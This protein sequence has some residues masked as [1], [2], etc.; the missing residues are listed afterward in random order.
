MKTTKH[1]NPLQFERIYL[2][3][4]QILGNSDETANLTSHICH[5]E[6]DL[7]LYKVLSNLL[8]ND[9]HIHTILTAI[10][11][12]EKKRLQYAFDSTKSLPIEAQ[13]SSAK[14]IINDFNDIQDTLLSTAEAHFD[15]I[16]QRKEL[17]IS[18]LETD[19]GNWGMRNSTNEIKTY[20]ETITNSIKNWNK[21]KVISIRNYCQGLTIRASATFIGDEDG[22]IQIK[23]NEEVARIFAIHASENDAFAV[24]E[25]E[26]IQLRLTIHEASGGIFTLNLGK[27]FPIYSEDRK[28]LNI[29][30]QEQIPVTISMGRKRQLHARLHD[31]SIGGIGIN[32]HGINQAPYN[33]GD[34]VE[35]QLTLNQQPIKLNGVVRWTGSGN[36]EARIGVELQ[37]SSHAQHLI[38]KEVFRMQRNIINTVNQLELPE[39]LKKTLEK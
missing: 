35:C 39:T 6:V 14:K 37:Q 25:G 31:L 34:K 36:D 4:R 15:E 18:P 5:E 1:K 10:S 3:L 24:C 2:T 38:Q 16:S 26:K 23:A 13:F 28:H 33:I 17:E 21:T 30:I 7:P 20:Q 29:Q 9:I 22:F 32:V 27:T 12:C 19:T 8:K 11:S